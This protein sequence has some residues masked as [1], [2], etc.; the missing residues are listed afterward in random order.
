M[1]SDSDGEQTGDGE[2]WGASFANASKV[3]DTNHRMQ[4]IN[5]PTTDYRLPTAD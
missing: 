5:A 2:Y 1:G 4:I 3:F